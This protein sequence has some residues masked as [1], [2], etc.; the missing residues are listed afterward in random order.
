[1]KSFILLFA[2][3]FTLFQSG[4]SDKSVLVEQDNNE[5]REMIIRADELRSA[6]STRRILTLSSDQDRLTFENTIKEAR[7]AL[8]RLSQNPNDRVA[9]QLGVRAIKA[10]ENMVINRGD[11]AYIDRFFADF[12]QVIHQA[13]RRAGVS[14]NDLTWRMYATNFSS[15]V[16]PWGLHSSFSD[17]DTDESLDESYIRV[18]GANN[19][20]WLLSPRFDLSDTVLPR[21]KI[22]HQTQVDRND[23]IGDPFHRSQINR[24]AFSA[25]VS[26]NYLGG[27]PELATWTRVD[28]GT[29]PTGTDFHT[30]ESPYIDLSAF[31]GKQVTIAFLYNT[32]PAVIGSHYISWTL[33]RFEL[34]AQGYVRSI[35]ST[36]R[37]LFEQQFTNNQAPF[38]LKQMQENSPVFQTTRSGLTL[39]AQADHGES[40]YIGP[41]IHVERMEDLNLL[42]R[43]EFENADLNQMQVLISNDFKGG[44]PDES[45]WTELT[46]EQTPDEEGL[47]FSGFTLT[48]LVEGPFVI[49]FRFKGNIT[50]QQRWQINY[51]GL[52][53]NVQSLRTRNI[54][55]FWRPEWQS[56]SPW[57]ITLAEFDF[58]FSTEG[59]RESIVSGRPASWGLTT[60]SNQT[61]LLITGFDNKEQ[62]RTQF[63]SPVVTLPETPSTFQVHQ[64][65]NFGRNAWQRG[66]LKILLLD[67]EGNQL[68]DITPGQVPQGINW[69]Y[70]TSE[71]VEIPQQYLGQNVRIAFE[72]ASEGEF[73][74]NWNIQWARIQTI[75]L[76]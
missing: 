47:L 2:L 40:W 75:S 21:F 76:D 46:R 4:C 20:A 59:F 70:I 36:G 56:G 64:A 44:N 69:D 48:D 49:A 19:R 22:V 9:I 39:N 60:R 5:Y 68:E 30:T 24:E 42:L 1:M 3:S 55:H 53:G 28:L 15:G 61:Y 7:Y 6:Y 71:K 27:D 29:M 11:Q 14:L 32:D 51:L 17:W 41:E 34:V 43:E 66:F 16:A 12:A 31:K 62:G 10:R 57:E 8:I 18:R 38:T 23:R 26:T 67:E 74:P 50:S 13:A 58:S 54:N 52:S 72:Y 35:T 63:Q 33:Y 37:T 25:L 73:F 65:M 45:N